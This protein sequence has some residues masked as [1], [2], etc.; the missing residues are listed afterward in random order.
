MSSRQYGP[1]TMTMV[2]ASWECRSWF[3]LKISRATRMSEV[4]FRFVGFVF[5][6]YTIIHVLIILL[7]VTIITRLKAIVIDW[8]PNRHDV[9][10]HDIIIY[11]DSTR[12]VGGN[13]V[14]SCFCTSRNT[15]Q[16]GTICQLLGDRIVL[17]RRFLTSAR[18]IAGCSSCL[19]FLIPT[20]FSAVVS[21]SHPFRVL[22][23]FSSN[24]ETTAKSAVLHSV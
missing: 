23:L 10:G 21:G 11:A 16:V 5:F 4:G 20:L 2:V 12:V 13:F 7:T 18:H 17:H 22:F 1:A 15:D 3:V 6:H 19:V 14:S 8:T 24:Y 9:T